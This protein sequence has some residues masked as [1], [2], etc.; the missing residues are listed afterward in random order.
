MKQQKLLVGT[1]G[2]SY[3][4]WVGEVYPEGTKKSDFLPLYSERFSFTELNFSYYRLPTSSTLEAI[5][6]KVPP[7]FAFAVKAHQSMTH[8]RGEAW[9]Q[10]A[11][12]FL[13]ALTDAGAAFPLH[14]VL[15]QFPYSFH[16][17]PENRRYLA[18]LTDA[19][20]SLRLYVEFRNAEWDQNDVYDEMER[21]RLSL[22]I[23]DMPR[24]DRLPTIRPRLTSSH[25]YIRFH[26]RNAKSWWQGTNVTRYDYLY[27]K[28]ELE[29]WVGP[30]F[31]LA[32]QAET[33]TIAFNNHYAGQAVTNA[34]Q[35]IE[36]LEGV[37]AT[38]ST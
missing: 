22:V 1:S 7:D 19:L 9:Q 38:R 33:I 17:T 8:D 34:Q 12:A 4:D 10:Q 28:A 35:M 30:V 5:A 20:S 26:G 16:Y 11:E 15:L 23:P 27:S 2:Y 14:G 29:E 36:L 24:L 13:S 25:A 18:S 21:R 37:D 6:A 31:D 32:D 3:D